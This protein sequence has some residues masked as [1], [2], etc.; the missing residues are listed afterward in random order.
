MSA[1]N[2]VWRRETGPSTFPEGQSECV[3]VCV[4]ARAFGLLS[5]GESRARW[6]KTAP[7]QIARYLTPSCIAHIDK[8][9]KRKA[10]QHAF[11]S[12]QCH[13]C[14]RRRSRYEAQISVDGAWRDIPR[15]FRRCAPWCWAMTLCLV[16][17]QHRWNYSCVKCA[18]TSPKRAETDR[19]RFDKL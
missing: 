17:Y 4:C 7:C 12:S 15:V 18:E 10:S 13:C 8:W 16:C 1:A 3:R 14:R 2:T 9:L 6:S 5:L 19:T 11:P